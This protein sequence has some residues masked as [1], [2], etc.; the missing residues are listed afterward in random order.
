MYFS[1]PTGQGTT[2]V[3]AGVPTAFVIAA[4]VIVTIVLGIFPGLVLDLADQS[5]VFLR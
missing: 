2:V 4:G 3:M 5:A 1:E